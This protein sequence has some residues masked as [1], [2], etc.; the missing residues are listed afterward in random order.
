MPGD[1][2]QEQSKSSSES[3]AISAPT[4]ARPGLW[5]IADTLE[6]LNREMEE[7][8]RSQFLRDWETWRQ[9]KARQFSTAETLRFPVRRGD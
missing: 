9:L 4:V 6:A 7:L 1:Q 8:S 2:S 3:Q 5:Q